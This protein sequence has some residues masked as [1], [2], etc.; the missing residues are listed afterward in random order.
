MQLAKNLERL[1]A[2]I[3]RRLI[4]PVICRMKCTP[5]PKDTRNILATAVFIQLF[6]LLIGLSLAR[7]TKDSI[8][9]NKTGKQQLHSNSI[10]LVVNSEFAAKLF[11]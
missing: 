6:R 1:S 10:G 9:C 3:M 2:T 7:G 5:L 4:Y 11:A 8:A